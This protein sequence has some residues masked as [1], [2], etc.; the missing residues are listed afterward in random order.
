M[1]EHCISLFQEE[2]ADETYR[3]YVTELLSSIAQG[4]GA[5]INTRYIDILHPKEQKSAEEI[6][7]H[8]KEGLS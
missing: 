2:Q 8:I 5:K 3:I 1:I 6:I 4:M 7:S